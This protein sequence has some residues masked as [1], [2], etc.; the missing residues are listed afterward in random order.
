MENSTTFKTGDLYGNDLTVKV[1]SR[2]KKTVTI[3]T[4]AWGVAR[5]KIRDWG[6]GVEYISYKAWLI[7]AAELFNKEEATRISHER[8]YYN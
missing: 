3:E 1:I 6:N 5:V 8:A 2:T 7:T 4:T